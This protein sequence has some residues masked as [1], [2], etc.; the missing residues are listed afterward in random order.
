[1]L[2]M[3]KRDGGLALYFDCDVGRPRFTG[4]FNWHIQV[5]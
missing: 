1:M 3:T 2:A 5:A 4:Y